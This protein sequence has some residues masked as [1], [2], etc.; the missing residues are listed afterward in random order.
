MGTGI[1]KY[2]DRCAEQLN[3]DDSFEIDVDGK[4]DLCAKCASTYRF[5]KKIKEEE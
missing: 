3:Y 1:G 2:C 5:D 4:Y